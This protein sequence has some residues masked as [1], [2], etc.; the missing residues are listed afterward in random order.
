MQH[1]VTV[2]RDSEGAAPATVQCE[3]AVLRRMLR[4]G[5]ANRK[6]GQLPAFPTITVQNA[7]S[8]FFER[9]EFERLRAELPPYLQ[10]LV[11][12]AYWIG[13]RL[14]ELLALQWRQVD[15]ARGTVS[16]AAGDHQERRRA[17]RLSPARSSFRAQELAR[18]NDGRRAREKHHR[19]Q[20]LSP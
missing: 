1:Y 15:L 20:R 14:G 16:L 2:R 4:L 11:T 10:P 6:V 18:A 9:D 7:R 13:W 17:V 12:V 3:I 8:G 5:Y 19:R